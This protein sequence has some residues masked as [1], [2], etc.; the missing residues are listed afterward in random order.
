MSETVV[1]FVSSAFA[2]P[3]PQLDRKAISA[4]KKYSFLIGISFIAGNSKP[5]KK[6]NA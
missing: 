5:D 1:V 4:I 3:L 2:P 6:P